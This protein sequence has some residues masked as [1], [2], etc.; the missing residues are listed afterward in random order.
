MGGED[1]E[2]DA[3]VDWLKAGGEMQLRVAHLKEEIQ[4]YL[5]NLAFN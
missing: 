3:S 5:N 4:L 1:L 2:L